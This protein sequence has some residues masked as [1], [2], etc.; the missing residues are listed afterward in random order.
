MAVDFEPSAARRENMERK[1]RN[2]NALFIGLLACCFVSACNSNEEKL[3]N[4]AL[5]NS[6]H[7]MI[8]GSYDLKIA[9]KAVIGLFS[10]EDVGDEYSGY[11]CRKNSLFCTG[12]LIHPNWVLT[13]AHCVTERSQWSGSISASACNDSLS[14]GVGN[15]E[16]AVVNKSYNVKKV[17]WH[18]SYGQHT[19]SS[20][21]FSSDDWT[22]IDADIALLELSSPVPESVA[23]PILPHPN[24]L[25]IASKDLEKEMEF[26]GFGIDE[27]GDMGTKLRFKTQVTEYCGLYNP[28]DSTDG[29]KNG[30]MKMNGCHP[31]DSYASRGYCYDNEYENILIPFGGYYYSQEEG[32]PCQGDSGGPGFYMIGGV[33]YVS[34][35]TSYGDYICGGFGISTAVQDYY[36]WIIQKAPAVASQYVEVC[37]NGVDDDGNGKADCDDSACASLSSCVVEICGNGIDDDKNGKTDCDD[38]ACASE[39]ACQVEICNDKIDNNANGLTDCEESVCLQSVYCQPEICDDNKDNNLDGKTDC[40]DAQCADKLI[41]QPEICNDNIDNNGNGLIDCDD[42]GCSAEP[43]CLP[44]ICDDNIDNNDN[45]LIDCK[46]PGC[47]SNIVCQPEIC[48]DNVD[49]NGNGL[50]D[51]D[52]LACL[53]AA[54]CVHP[55]FAEICDDHIDNNNDGLVDCDDPQCSN[56]SLCVVMPDE[57]CSDFVDNNGNGLIDCDDPQCADNIACSSQPGAPEN[58]DDG[59]DNNGD[60]L[61]DCDDSQCSESA[62]CKAKPGVLEICDDGVDNNGNNMIDCDDSDCS[63]FSSCIAGPGVS[64]ICD[65]GIDNDDNRLI[66]CDD[67]ACS[68]SASCGGTSSKPGDYADGA[69]GSSSESGLSYNDRFSH[70]PEGKEQPIMFECSSTPLRSAPAPLA[71]LFGLLGTGWMLRRRRSN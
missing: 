51:C 25:P 35:V 4:P 16:N 23:K 69:E 11:E 21:W 36:D 32:G 8:N 28:H 22:T 7:A 14:I 17:Y 50:V 37:G 40:E 66:D 33:E 15:N 31:N 38:Q 64:E 62:S 59:I 53:K 27:D 2:A 48:D 5:V 60:G 41:C 57:N 42:K 52:D 61:V 70:L 44:E 30:S 1:I 13:A 56:S 54:K 12:T 71:I 55:E 10:T 3:P 63:G 45:G 20:S 49:N 68:V 46:D 29:C 9:H 39:R 24:W 47:T 34:G 19:L 65:D 67:P 26:S 18:P 43:A 6:Q 58:C